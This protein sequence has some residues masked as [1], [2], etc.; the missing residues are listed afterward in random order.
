V[1][2]I[3]LKSLINEIG[4]IPFSYIQNWRI[5]A[6]WI[7]PASSAALLSLP[8]WP[9]VFIPF[10][11]CHIK[12]ESGGLCFKLLCGCSIRSGTG[13]ETEAPFYHNG[14][15]YWPNRA[16]TWFAGIA[17]PELRLDARWKVR[18]SNPGGGEI[19]RTSPDRPWGLTSL[20]Y[21]GYWISFLGVKRP[22]LGVNHPPP[23]SAQ[24][25]E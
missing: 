24:V 15:V 14:T 17:Q 6:V 18:G 11:I 16:R 20:Q 2:I 9:D 3:S 5:T 12:Q 1:K 21:N 7:L 23:S 4:K 19:F 22:S 25:K 10:C 13:E 8:T